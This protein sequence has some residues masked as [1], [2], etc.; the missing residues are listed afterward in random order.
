MTCSLLK[1]YKRRII[2]L[3]EDLLT[4][5]FLTIAKKKITLIGRS[6]FLQGLLINERYQNKPFFKKNRI[7]LK[8]TLTI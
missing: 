6:I 4:K 3:T 5:D 7:F 1:F 2:Y 8:D